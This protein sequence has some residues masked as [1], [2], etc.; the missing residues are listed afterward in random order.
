MISAVSRRDPDQLERY[1]ALANS[2][3]GLDLK[4][5][6][7]LKDLYRLEL[8]HL[9]RVLYLSD[10]DEKASIRRQ[11]VTLRNRVSRALVRSE[12]VRRAERHGIEPLKP[13]HRKARAEEHFVL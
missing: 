6:S 9:M 13:S 4:Q 2:Y 12:A 5:E 10:H 7:Q 11:A 3:H 8:R 1:L